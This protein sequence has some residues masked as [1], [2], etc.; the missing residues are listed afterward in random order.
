MVIPLDDSLFYIEPLYL[1]AET[2]KIP[3][4]KRVIV[5]SGENVVMANTF[6]EGLAQLFG[7]ESPLAG[8]QNVETSAATEAVSE[9]DSGGTTSTAT[10]PS[11]AGTADEQIAAL[12]Q[13]AAERYEAAQAALQEGDWATYGAELEA[14]KADLDKLLELTDGEP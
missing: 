2:G 12:I 9:A 6:A 7:D 10:P 11:A 4:L 13:S 8:A 1:Q 3:E 14:M 5:S